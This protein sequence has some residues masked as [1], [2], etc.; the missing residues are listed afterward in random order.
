MPKHV[1]KA[2]QRKGKACTAWYEDTCPARKGSGGASTAPANT[3]ATP[4]PSEEAVPEEWGDD[5]SVELAEALVA[6]IDNAA[7]EGT[8]SWLGF[9]LL[10]GGAALIFICTLREKRAQERRERFEKFM[11]VADEGESLN[12]ASTPWGALTTP[13]RPG[14]GGGGAPQPP[15]TAGA[16]DEG[17]L[18]AHAR[19]LADAMGIGAASSRANTPMGMAAAAGAAAEAAVAAREAAAGARPPAPPP[20]SP[21]A[22]QRAAQIAAEAEE[23]AVKE[24]VKQAALRDI[25][26]RKERKRLQAEQMRE[27]ALQAEREAE[28]ET[29]REELRRRTQEMAEGA[30]PTPSPANSAATPPAP[31]PAKEDGLAAAEAEF[32]AAL[33]DLG[34]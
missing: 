19:A 32:L 6:M 26:E 4:K 31:S 22:A 27:K 1:H 21:H 25:E 16:A 3:S 2:L 13:R 17:V 10:L 7:G 29:A 34:Q 30:E 15:G 20:L 5:R 12:G 24:A 23:E 18:M 14:R 9:F 11:A 8:S 28:E 33:D